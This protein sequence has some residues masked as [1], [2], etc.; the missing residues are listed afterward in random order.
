MNKDQE[1]L[2]LYLTL[3]NSTYTKT[4]T[5]GLVVGLLDDRGNYDASVNT[6]P[7]TGGSGSSGAIKKGD[8]WYIS[9]TGTLGAI[10]VVPGDTIRALLDTPG[11]TANKWSVMQVAG[12]VAVS[13]VAANIENIDK[14]AAIDDEVALVAGITAGDVSKVAAID[15]EVGI[16]AGLNTEIEALALGLPIIT[17]KVLTSNEIST[18]VITIPIVGTFTNIISVLI[19][20]ATTGE[21]VP[22]TIAVKDTTNVVLTSGTTQTA[23]DD[24]VTV[25]VK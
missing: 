15:D 10:T 25:V 22:C 20:K 24:V 23:P 12:N 21:I 5:D 9:N 2:G 13:T 14:V 17:T 11:Q 18:Y 8:L 7:A 3:K 1:L 4:E 16:V 19:T 6:F